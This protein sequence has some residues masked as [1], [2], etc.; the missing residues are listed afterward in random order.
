MV[1]ELKAPESYACSDPKPEADKGD[2]KG[3]KIIDT[4]PSAIFSTTK[5]KREDPEDREDGECIFHSQMW[6]KGSPLHFLIYSISQNIVISVEVVKRLDLLTITHLQLYTIGWL[7]PRRDL[8][9]RQ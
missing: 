5:L 3:N 2:E 4:D 9:V 8:P 1:V 7:K 6:V